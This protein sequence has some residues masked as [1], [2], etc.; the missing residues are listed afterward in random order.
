MRGVS[1]SLFGATIPL[2]RILP[3]RNGDNSHDCFL[4][5]TELHYHPADPTPAEFAAGFTMDSAFEF[6]ELT[7]VT[8]QTLDLTG[9]HFT[10]GIDFTFTGSGVTLLAPGAS[11]LVVAN[12]AAFLARYGAALGT[13]IAGTFANGTSLSN[14]GEALALAD[15]ANL[16]IFSFAYGDT[17]PWPDGADGAGPSLVLQG[18]DPANPAHW[19]VSFGPAQPGVNLALK[20][21]WLRANFTAAEQGNAAF[22]G[23]PADADLDGLANFA[24]FATNSDPRRSESGRDAL[25]VRVQPLIVGGTPDNYLTVTFRR[26]TEPGYTVALQSS[27]DLATWTDATAALI[28]LAIDDPRTGW[29]TLTYRTPAP[30]VPGSPPNTFH[31]LRISKP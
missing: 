3:L 29:Q 24:E 6:L 1:G 21:E 12:T 10:A 9:C 18:T 28:L 16:P 25:T 17:A 26:T 13:Q 11:V 19:R 5:I 7:N 15:N 8:A 30:F 23:D 27:T 22:S 31:R 14:S 4:R 2:R 20:A